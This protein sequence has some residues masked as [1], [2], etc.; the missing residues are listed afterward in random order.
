MLGGSGGGSPQ[1]AMAGGPEKSKLKEAL[2]HVN[3]M[4][5]AHFKAK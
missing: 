2:N 1:I 5:L 3:E 4:F